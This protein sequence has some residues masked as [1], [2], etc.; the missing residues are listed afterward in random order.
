MAS[1]R[2]CG[3]WGVGSFLRPAALGLVFA[4]LLVA[5]TVAVEGQTFTVIHN[6]SGGGDGA[7]PYAG[8]TMDRTGAFYGTT[9]YGGNT[10]GSC[11]SI[12]GCGVVFQLSHLGSGWILK[13]LYRFTAGNDGAGPVARVI[14]GPNG[15]LYGT[16]LAGGGG[17][18]T[19]IYPSQGC[20]TVFSLTPGPVAPPS[21]LYPWVETVLHSFSG[22]DGQQPFAEVTFDPAGSIYG[23]AEQGGM[24][25]GLVYKLTPSGGGWTETVLY[26]FT[27][28][29]DG[30][31]PFGNLIFDG[32]GNLYGTTAFG[33]GTVYELTPSGPGWVETVLHTFLGTDGSEPYAG[34]VFDQ[35][36]NLYGSTITGGPSGG[37]TVF[38]LTPSGG[39][40]NETGLHSFSGA[41]QPGPFGNVLMDAGGNLYG[42]V[43]GAG[44]NQKGAVFKLSPSG[45]GW[46]YTSLHDFTG[47]ADG[48]F[49][50]GNLVF[51]SAGNLYGT[52]SAG[53][54]G[55]NCTG[56]C[57]VVFQIT[58]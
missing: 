52:A 32:G 54:T 21:V 15:Y 47:G 48:A 7:N 19:G 31:N 45:G 28:L 56:G 6:F 27:G 18:C 44:A 3:V 39:G 10:Q 40:W 11:A 5:G 41:T 24:N 57:G 43:V 1:L 14:V 12:N 4:I 42:T 36:G 22:P 20:G 2:Q 17:A 9:L 26:T 53:G 29:A 46:T 23:T 8:L 13:P 50:Y 25:Y 37:G 38:A 16:T 51:D 49:P 30:G 55:G 34:V 58:P 35:A 33:D